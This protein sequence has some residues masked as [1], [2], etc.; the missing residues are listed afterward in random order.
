MLAVLK[1]YPAGNN[2]AVGDGL[3][4][5]GYLFNAP[6]HSNQNTYIA[7]LDYKLDSTGKDS[8]FLRGNLQND[9]RRHPAVPR[10]HAQY[11]HAPNNK[12]LARG[13]VGVAPNLVST[14]HYGF[15]RQ[16]GE[17]TGILTAN[18]LPSAGS[19]RSTAPAPGSPHC[20]GTQFLRGFRLESWRSRFR[21]GF[22]GRLISNQSVNYGHAY[23]TA[24]TNASVINGSGNDLVPASIGLS[25]GDTT[26]FE[27]A[28]RRC[29][30]SSRRP[31]ATTTTRPMGP[32]SDRIRVTRN[33]ANREAELYAQD[34]WKLKN[35]LTVTYGLRLSIMPPV[36]E[37]NHQQ[38][39]TNI[40]I[41]AWMDTRG[42]LATQGLSDQAAGNITYS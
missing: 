6:V 39:S 19:T 40:P 25:K 8:L 5:I 9:S 10:G 37:A 30:A 26:S 3:N 21:F 15:T 22:G 1:Q 11:H 31:P 16:G 20:S 36:Y 2:T 12:G 29:S 17:T 34:S 35:N 4:T 38:I 18:P 7:R 32:H 27:Y 42:A 14:F 28:W 23:N 24:T 13:D 33:F 41:G